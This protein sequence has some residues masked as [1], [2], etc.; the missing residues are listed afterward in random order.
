MGNNSKDSN[1]AETKTLKENEQKWRD[2]VESTSDWIWEVDQDGIYTY[3]SPRIKEILGYKPEEILGKTPFEF[4]PG[5]EARRI[6]KF[7]TKLVSSQ[8]PIVNLE[9]T[10]LHK[11]GQPIILE[12]NGI[13]FY[14]VKGKFLGYRGVDRDISKSK[15]A[16]KA[17]QQSKQELDIRN[18]IA[19]AFLSNPDDEVYG[20]VLD[21]VL[22]AMN[23]KHGVFGYIDD[24]ENFVCP[25]MTRDIWDKCQIPDKNIIFPREKW[26]GIWGQALIEKK[27]KYSNEPSRVPQGHLPINRSLNVPIVYREKILGNILVANKKTPYEEKD[28]KLLETIGNYIAPVLDA[29]LQRDKNETELKQAVRQLK[30]ANE[31]WT[32]SFEETG[33]GMFIL[34][35][36]YTIIQANIAFA[37]IIGKE[38]KNIVGKNCCEIL[39]GQQSPP[40]NCVTNAAI[41]KRKEIE[42]EIFEPFLDKYL[43]VSADPVLDSEGSFEY[44]IHSIIDITERKRTE[45]DLIRLSAAIKQ[46]TENVMILDT[47]GNIQYLNPIMEQITGRTLEEIKDKNPF[48]T[49]KDLINWHV[50]NDDFQRIWESTCKGN[51]WKGRIRYQLKDG[52]YYDTDTTISSVRD[53]SGNIINLMLIGRD[54]TQELE[55]E[56]RLGQTSKIEAIGTLAGGI[57]HDFNNILG[58]ITGYSQMLLQDIAEDTLLHNNISEILTA[59]QRAKELIKQILV[60]S[61][62]SQLERKPVRLIPII[63]ESLK[64]MKSSLPSTIEIRQ[65]LQAE[66]DVV[67][68]DPTKI[69]QV[70]INLCANSKH[71]MLENGGVLEVGLYEIFLGKEDDNQYPDISPGPYL[72][73]TVSDTGKGIKQ[74]IID[75]IFDPF[76]TTKTVGEGTGLGLSVV[77]GIVKDCGGAIRVYSEHGKGTTFSIYFPQTMNEPA[78]LE[79]EINGTIT[80]G[81]ES[82]LLVDD[83]SSFLTMAKQI[84]ESLGYHV[85]AR[86]NSLKA[87]EIF[88]MQ[89]DKFDL[90]ITDQTMPNMTGIQLAEELM[91]IRSRIPIIICTG[92]SETLSEQKARAMGIRE[93]IMKPIIIN[94]M[95][96]AIQR[97]L[98][99]K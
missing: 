79:T 45:N 70:L 66:S 82:I 68:S 75:R 77:H 72:R 25:S 58:V 93:F 83:E 81:K 43:Q 95:A 27:T 1:K 42:E 53:N 47:N 3:A 80:K 12:T 63:K 69:H 35:K 39:H 91:R 67:I 50:N 87:L 32:R 17:L 20:D 54:I 33:R 78:E 99:I 74:K 4:M 73:L 37:R 65:N 85:S 31:R 52:T 55:Y 59:S 30:L 18:Q 8:K 40:V 90:V 56:K 89:P 26:G 24:D 97:A 16:E 5:D 88:R 61:R 41:S 84:L 9:N 92:F 6:K 48:L 57:A 76:F 23:S 98:K 34:D 10:N 71:A 36:N 28:I 62:Q 15:C 14:D 22:N 38:L 96:M 49:E 94:D 46:A 60:F 29:R 11:N 51:I 7:F 21:I 19:T 44:A 13:P 2:L 64:F 86:N